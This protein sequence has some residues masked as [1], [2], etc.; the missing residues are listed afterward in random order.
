MTDPRTKPCT[1]CGAPIIFLPTPNERLMPV[2][3]GTVSP[4]DAEY[5]P[6]KHVSHWGTCPSAGF[7]KKRK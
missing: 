3:A 2:N 6:V 7:H 5:D 4:D 1:S